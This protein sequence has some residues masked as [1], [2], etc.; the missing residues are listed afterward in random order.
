[1]HSVRVIAEVGVNHN[2][3]IDLAVE[4]VE[5]AAAAG[6]DIVKFQSFSAEALV[7]EAAPKAPYQEVSTGAGSQLD[8]LKRLELSRD[9]HRVLMAACT[10]L[11][12]GFLS[13]PFDLASV[14]LLA[15]L[16]VREIKIASSELTD[17]PLLR[18]VG[19]LKVPAIVSTGM[20]TLHEVSAALDALT[21]AGTPRDWITL[22]HCTSEYPTPID[23]VNLRAM[24]TLEHTFGLPVGFSDH[25]EG[26]EVAIAAAARGASVVEKHFTLDRNAPGPDHRASL[27]PHDFARMV[28]AVRLVE[29]ALGDPEKR[30]SDGEHAVSAVA[31]KSIVAARDIVEGEM[32]DDSNLTTKRPAGGIDPMHWDSLV[33]TRAARAYVRDEMIEP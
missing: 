24:T 2:G 18:A 5:A 27:E 29:R 7:A 33:G 20:A 32:L 21:A 23:D 31:R 3:D 28:D 11:G 30:P 1:M 17:L 6:A 12:V 15:E 13:A 9:D 8:M 26:I 16:G 19:A 10:R 25:T 22:L 14:D 4:M